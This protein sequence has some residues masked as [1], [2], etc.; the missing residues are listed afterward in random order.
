MLQ[1]IT[2]NLKNS[3]KYI[4]LGCVSK[5]QF[6]NVSLNSIK[7]TL[8]VKNALAYHSNVYNKKSFFEQWGLFAV[9]RVVTVQFSRQNLIVSVANTLAYCSNMCT[10]LNKV[11]NGV[12]L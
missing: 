6:K 9:I 1:V 4:S 8:P 3:F 5:N 7:L 10:T 12:Y 2:S 11:F